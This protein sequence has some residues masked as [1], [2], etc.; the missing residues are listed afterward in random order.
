MTFYYGPPRA[1]SII[2]RCEHCVYCLRCAI[3]EIIYVFW[4]ASMALLK[5]SLFH[6]VYRVIFMVSP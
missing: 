6:I 5:M 3:N 1:D 4:L 2:I